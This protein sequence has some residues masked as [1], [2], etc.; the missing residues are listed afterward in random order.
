M[1]ALVAAAFLEAVTPAE[2]DA[3]ERA[4]VTRSESEAALRRAAAQQVE[5]LRYRALLAER[6][7]DKVDPDNRLVAA[8]LERRWEAALCELRAAETALAAQERA[9]GDPEAAEGPTIAASSTLR[10][11]LLEIQR[12]LPPLWADPRLTPAQRKALLRCL[13][14]KV[15]LERTAADRVNLRIVWCGGDWSDLVADT[16]G[17]ALRELSG[18]AEIERCVAAMARSGASDADIAAALNERGYRLAHGRPVL[19]NTVRKLRL[20]QGIRYR[21]EF[22]RRVKGALTL[23]QLAEAVGVSAAWIHHRIRTGRIT[24]THGS[25]YRLYLF[26]DEPATINV[27]RQLV[28]GELR[29]I[30]LSTRQRD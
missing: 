12:S 14:E 21:P 27:L 18:I 26:P 11:Q 20:A 8:E 28:R 22:R 29:H 9:G 16:G 4:E 17:H 15:V 30:D 5:R 10:M 13:I 7:F 1:D 24:V 23:P 19:V 25:K 2:A 6:Q 3:F